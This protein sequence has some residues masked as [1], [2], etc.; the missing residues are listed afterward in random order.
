MKI[1][2]G[3]CG[4]GFKVPLSVYGFEFLSGICKVS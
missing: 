1:A 4:F 2:Q 3:I